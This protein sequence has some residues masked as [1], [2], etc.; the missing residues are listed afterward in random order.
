LQR[1]WET[2][3]L[4]NSGAMSAQLEHALCAYLGVEHLGLLA[5]GTL[6][7]MV[8][9]KALDL[10]GEVI[11][12]PYTFVATPHAL[13]WAGVQPVFVDIAPRTLTL[14]PARI[15]AAITPRTTAI[16]PVHCYGN[17]CDVEAIGAIAERHGLKVVYDAAHAFAVC[18]GAGSLMRHGDLSVLS[19]HA[20]KVFST[21]EGGAIVC[22]DAAMLQRIK[23]LRNFGL[24]DEETVTDVGINGKMNEVCA[25]FGLFQLAHVTEVLAKLRGLYKSYRSALQDVEGIRCL[26]PYGQEQANHGFFPVLVETT[27]PLTRDALYAALCDAG[28]HARR[29]FFPLVTTFPMYADHTSAA[30]ANL[31]V[32]HA[33]SEQVLCLPIFAAMTHAQ[34]TQV[35]EVIRHPWR[36]RSRQP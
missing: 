16:M 6:A 13:R 30:R 34:Q 14:D 3:W 11:T 15:E 5:N 2:K 21:I 12:T 25:A 23:R 26:E 24:A 29:Y 10:S 1:I 27:Y 33:I 18:D 4:T 9:L 36:H 28:V 22:R 19:F 32:A 31:P 8:A 35:V 17:R 20:T 7:L